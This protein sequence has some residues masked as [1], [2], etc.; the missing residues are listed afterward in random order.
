MTSLETFR[1]VLDS[2]RTA[3]TN[4]F[5]VRI[6]WPWN[7]NQGVK[8]MVEY[9]CESTQI[10]SKNITTSSVRLEHAFFES[11][12]GISYEPVTLTF[13]LDEDLKLRDAFVQWYKTIY[14]DTSNGLNFYSDYAR[15]VT[16][17]TVDKSSPDN[18]N[19]DIN[20]NY[21]VTLIHAYPKSI[22]DINFIA[23]SD[24]QVATMQVQF[25]YE[26]LTESV[27]AT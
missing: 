11:P 18:K 4:G 27:I 19:Y 8:E 6:D 24:G 3:R 15:T 17:R 2:Y 1:K 20:G 26:R 10:P 21:E 12:Y 16:I 7:I 14:D 23:S 25:V 5:Y 9:Y 22:G 13:Y